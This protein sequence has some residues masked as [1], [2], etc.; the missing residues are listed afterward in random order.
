MFTRLIPTD[1]IFNAPFFNDIADITLKNMFFTS[2]VAGTFTFENATDSIG[3]SMQCIT[4]NNA[5]WRYK[6]STNL[7][8]TN[9]IS[10]SFWFKTSSTTS[11][12]RIFSGAYSAEFKSSFT[13]DYKKAQ[14]GNKIEFGDYYGSKNI[15]YAD[16]ELNNNRWT[17]I[18][19]TNDRSLDAETSVNFYINGSLVTKVNTATNAD[20]NDNYNL[21]QNDEFDFGDTPFYGSLARFRV[22]PRILALQEITALY[23][24]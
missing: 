10:I 5:K 12:Q 18:T 22:Y 8:T 16:V 14:S 6:H 15:K 13:I 7:A 17:L 4:S 9:K 23:Y 11:N 3:K 1:Y 21:L 19:I 2:P 20:V 24:E